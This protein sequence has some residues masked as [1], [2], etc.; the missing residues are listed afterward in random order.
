MVVSGGQQGNS[1]LYIYI[2]VPI[3]LKT[4]LP[5]R[6]LHN[7]EQSSLCSSVETCLILSFNSL[8]FLLSLSVIYIKF[9]LYNSAIQKSGT[10]GKQPLSEC[11]QIFH[12]EHEQW[13]AGLLVK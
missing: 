2:Y 12:L 11:L 10:W 13:E 4:P 7:I 8:E 6:L 5:A 1:A 9:F 3:L